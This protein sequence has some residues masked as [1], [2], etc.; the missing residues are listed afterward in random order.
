MNTLAPFQCVPTLPQFVR[1]KTFRHV[2]VVSPS[3]FS[4]GPEQK[5]KTPFARLNGCFCWFRKA[6]GG[7][8]PGDA[9]GPSFHPGSL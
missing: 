1:C 3:H 8:M 2:D 5:A 7:A 4:T 6:V 9:V